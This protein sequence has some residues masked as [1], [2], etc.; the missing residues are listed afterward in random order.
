M[1]FSGSFENYKG[2]T[3]SVYIYSADYPNLNISI[4]DEQGS[5]VMFSSD[6]L[7]IITE[8]EDTFTPII[9]KTATVNLYSKIYLGDYL[10]GK[11]SRSVQIEIY[12]ETE[13]IFAGFVE[14]N[15]Y[16]QPYVDVYDLVTV[17]C[18]DALSTLEY[19]NYANIIENYDTYK[20]TATNK[21][22]ADII[23][24]ILKTHL[25]QIDFVGNQ[26]SRVFYD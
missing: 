10:F 4:G 11:N 16:S 9:K 21:T 15:V 18:V 13:C 20:R 8:Q 2:V 25:G 3:Y 17:N 23:Q 7:E 26:D 22:F 1:T 19:Y 5:D 14:P 24:N 12:K 6:A